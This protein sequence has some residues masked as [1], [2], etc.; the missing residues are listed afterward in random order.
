MY[1]CIAQPDEYIFTLA[2]MNLKS[3]LCTVVQYEHLITF[4]MLLNT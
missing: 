4:L 2:D 1:G 3:W